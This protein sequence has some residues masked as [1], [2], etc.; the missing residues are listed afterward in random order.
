MKSRQS[1]ALWLDLFALW[2]STLVVFLFVVSYWPNQYSNLSQAYYRVLYGLTPAV[3]PLL[4]RWLPSFSC[5]NGMRSAYFLGCIFWCVY[6]I[7]RG[8]TSKAYYGLTVIALLMPIILML[9]VPS[10]CSGNQPEVGRGLAPP[11]FFTASIN[12]VQWIL[13]LMVIGFCIYFS[14]MARSGSLML[15]LVVLILYFGFVAAWR[16][17]GRYVENATLKSIVLL[18]LITICLTVLLINGRSLHQDYDYQYGGYLRYLLVDYAYPIDKANLSPLILIFYLD[19]FVNGQ[20]DT[21]LEGMHLFPTTGTPTFSYGGDFGWIEYVR[22]FGLITISAL[23]L[24]VYIY[25]SGVRAY[26]S[27]SAVVGFYLFWGLLL[28]LKFRGLKSP[29]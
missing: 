11:L 23:V 15:W 13:M 3:L 19:Y 8:D 25:I 27:N 29:I 18:T 7:G 10:S 26:L 21:L 4:L 1:T 17:F 6:L 20:L 12:R 14:I 24:N 28:L 16:L 22:E 2:L 9:I 5:L